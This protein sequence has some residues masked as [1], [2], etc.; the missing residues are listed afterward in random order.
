M[1]ALSSTILRTVL[2]RASKSRAECV[3]ASGTSGEPEPLCAVYH[4]DCLPA[5][6]RAIADKR[7]RMNDLLAELRTET[8]TVAS[9]GLV[10][11]NTPAEWREFCEKSE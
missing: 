6:Q 4:R 10:N 9:L 7:F 11:L 2:E 5:L 3:A 1:P 8:V